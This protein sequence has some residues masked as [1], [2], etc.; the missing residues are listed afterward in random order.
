M[1]GTVTS[2]LTRI[3]AADAGT[4]ASIG[5]GN[6]PSVNTDVF[7]QGTGSFARRQSAVTDH[8]FWYDNAG[9]VD[10][11]ASEVHVGVWVWHTHF[12]VLTKLALRFG[13]L[14]TNYD[15]HTVPLSEYPSSGGWVRV[16]VDISRTPT[17]TGGTGLNEAQARYF[18]EIASLPSV[19]GTS[20]NLVMDAIDH[21]TTGLIVTGGTVPSPAV[22]S[23]FVTADEGN[24]TNKYGV[25]TTR[26]GINYIQARITL[27]SSG[28]AVIFN[29]V[30][31]VVV[32]PEQSLVSSTFMGLSIDLANAGTDIDIVDFIIKSA[33]A[34]NK[35]DIVVT[36][37]SGL[38]LISGS[39]ITS[40]RIIT[41]TSG[42]DIVDCTFQLC[43]LLTQAGADL[44]GCVFDKPSGA[45]GILS[46]NPSLITDC[47][48]TSDGTGHAIE[49]TTPGSYTLD[50]DTFTGYAATDGSTGNEAIYNNSGGA[51]TLSITG[52]G[53]T[54]TIRNGA[55][56]STTV[57]AAV[58]V[59]LTAQVS[60]VGAEIRVYDL[61][62]SPAGSLGTEITGTES[63]SNP[64][65][66]FSTSAGNLVWIQIMLSGYEE[67]GLEITVP[68]LNADIPITLSIDK[69]T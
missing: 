43:G 45:V 3:T 26:S 33:G 5:G 2:S 10:L 14:T 7:I 32:F 36:G 38:A 1:A 52:G 46:N 24:G 42:V 25:I 50:N 17:T 20:Q 44:T 19:G 23:D 62:N 4:L 35:G 29:D 27:G 68:T 37:T 6:G 60:L 34:T 51:V 59:T 28:T 13:T 67:F 56:A 8:G 18:G 30:G 65:F 47:F 12:A 69:N 41:L 57:S 66:S 16:W 39:T 22:I 49:I 55:G 48:F 61:D 58:T 63:Q 21:T 9:N 40:M 11:S 15:E 64:S 31:Q 54:P 53:N